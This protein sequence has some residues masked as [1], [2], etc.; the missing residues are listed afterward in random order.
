MN[1]DDYP[2][3]ERR[4]IRVQSIDTTS[5][6]TWCRTNHALPCRTIDQC[7]DGCPRTLESIGE[8][9]TGTA[10]GRV[11]Y[12]TT[13]PG[14]P[15]TSS[16]LTIVGGY[17]SISLSTLGAVSMPAPRPELTPEQ[18]AHSQHVARWESRV[19]E[20]CLCEFDR[21]GEVIPSSCP[22]H[23]KGVDYQ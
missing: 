11:A 2:M 12:D 13:L 19:I 10:A 7:P 9:E 23:W 17:A 22:V 4:G 1:V 15:P 8:L 5:E 3:A 20:L 18:R 16:S 14:R 6:S 21:W